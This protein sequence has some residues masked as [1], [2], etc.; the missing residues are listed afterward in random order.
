MDHQLTIVVYQEIYGI[1]R[2]DSDVPVPEWAGGARFLSV[3]RTARELSIV[4]EEAMMPVHVYAERNRR[5]MQI[6]GTLGF[7]LPGVLASVAAPV[8]NAGISVFAVSAYDS[9]YLVVANED[10]EEAT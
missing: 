10:L 9:D 6:E 1:C 2:L 7:T 3:T 4:C 8:G 5:L